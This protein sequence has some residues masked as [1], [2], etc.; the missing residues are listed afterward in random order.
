[1]LRSNENLRQFAYVASHDLQE[2][3]RKIQTYSDLLNSRNKNSEMVGK[4]YIEKIAAGAKRMSTLIKALLEFSQAER[5]DELFEKVDLNVILNNIKNDYEVTIGEKHA[6]IEIDNLCT[7]EA[8]PLQMNQLFYNL[9]GNALKFSKDGEEPFVNVTST[10][11]DGEDVARLK[12]HKGV[13]YCEICVKDN[14]IGFDQKYADQ[15]FVLFQRLHVRDKYEG[16]GIGLALC[17]KIVENHKGIL[18]VESSVGE[19]TTFRIV[20]PA[21]RI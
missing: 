19:G 12:L 9:V 10:M 8:I 6:T 14:G 21:R 1:L 7:I 13:E 3:L 2:P 20:L 16:T 11:L 18:E 15:I 5:K 4:E 17:K